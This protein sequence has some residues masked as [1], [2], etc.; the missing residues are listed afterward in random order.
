MRASR[1]VSAT[2]ALLMVRLLTRQTMRSKELAD[3]LAVSRSWAN[4]TLKKLKAKGLVE[5]TE[6]K[7]Y[8]AT[9][10]G[11]KWD[12]SGWIVGRTYDESIS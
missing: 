11:K 8:Q 4:M 6:T 1:A 12:G 9:E 2:R 3:R 7:A 5:Q 10:L